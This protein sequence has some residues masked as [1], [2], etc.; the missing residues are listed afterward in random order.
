MT[1]T[2]RVL[3][4]TTWGDGKL[5]LERNLST[6]SVTVELD[7][8]DS[9][10]EATTALETT[11]YDW[12]VVGDGTADTILEQ[13]RPHLETSPS[14]RVLLYGISGKDHVPDV[15]DSFQDR[16]EV[17]SARGTTRAADGVESECGGREDEREKIEGQQGTQSHDGQQGT[18]HEESERTL[19]L[20]VAHAIERDR[21]DSKR[22]R[23]QRRASLLE[24]LQ[25]GLV[26]ARTLEEIDETLCA[27]FL[28]FDP[29]VF[30][31]IG[32]H[33]EETKQVVPRHSAGEGEEYL[34]GLE[35]TTDDA[36][37]GQGP[38]GRA[39]RTGTLQVNQN[40]TRDPTYDAWRADALERGFHSSVAVPLVD[41]D[42][43]YGVLNLYADRTHAFDGAERQLLST[44]ADVAGGAYARVTEQ[45]SD[46]ARL[47]TIFDK[48]PD[49]LVV[50]DESG[51]IIDV[52]E[53]AVDRLGYE[54]TTL[55]EMNVSELLPERSPVELRELWQSLD[56]GETYR[57]EATYQTADGSSHPVETWVRAMTV[58]GQRQF[59]TTS[60]DI[61]E[62]KHRERQLETEREMFRQGPVV[63]F[64]WRNEPGWPVEYV[65][66]NVQEVLGYTPAEL[67]AEDL[68]FSELVFPDDRERIL[69]ELE[70]YAE[71]A[72]S[73]FKHE[74]YRIRTKD[75]DHRWVLEYTTT[76]ETDGA[77]THLLGYML[78]V[79]ERKEYEQQLERYQ[80]LVENLPVGIYRS[81]LETPGEFVEVNEAMVD[82]F[83]AESSAELLDRPVRTLFADPDDR[84]A[85]TEQ[86][87]SEG[88]VEVDELTLE[89]LS[90]ETFYASLTAI[91]SEADDE[92][93]IDGVVQ[94]VTDRRRYEYQ[95]ERQRDNLEVLNQVVRH[96]IRNDLQLILTYGEL[97]AGSV[98]DQH[99]QHVEKILS[100]TRSAIE[101]TD[102]AREVAEVMLQAQEEPKPVNAGYV[103][104]RQL[105][106]VRSS[107]ENALVE[108]EGP[109]PRVTVSA[110]DMLESVFRNL[111]VNAVEHND[112]D[113]PEVRVSTEQREETLEVS[114]ADN[115]PGIPDERK[116]DIFEEGKKGLDSAGTGLGLYLVQTLLDRYGGSIE[117]SDN[118]PEGTVF[119]VALPIVETDSS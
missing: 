61:T 83:D 69:E 11:A 21:L 50:H 17:V 43:S 95:L 68:D 105:D 75:G 63:V 103:L 29:Y 87:E 51:E 65:S 33:Q 108:T 58:D 116:Q 98:D 2:L 109:I 8:V 44:I 47:R 49:A 4:F 110:D 118:E 3:H 56:D 66:E 30:A 76:V 59:L 22:E 28:E 86:L 79:T 37:T 5:T 64:K 82:I 71:G 12:V 31:W 74:P 93:Y 115:G 25:S 15:L 10:G 1:E 107:Y 78:D 89:T 54:Q 111:L 7:C 114:I 113:V 97:L 106:A 92:C 99:R 9:V 112:E 96:D 84:H 62:R 119:T 38:T 85:L 6:L 45:A 19:A 48:A 72:V 23:A 13:L 41:G 80:Q 81:T 73:H 90:G 24:R 91:V 77:V 100:S 67:Q 18:Q 101:I 16:L 32:D 70:T 55:L 53:R 60:R 14:T 117:V 20:R 27:T 26:R 34:D 104:E 35:I 88:Y 52:N 57:G 102:S 42:Q 94:D 36:S 39:V 40:V 46:R